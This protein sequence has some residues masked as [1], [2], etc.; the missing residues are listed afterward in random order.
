M[1]NPRDDFKL[2]TRAIT[3]RPVSAQSRLVAASTWCDVDVYEFI[4]TA[5]KD[6]L[7]E[8]EAAM[9]EEKNAS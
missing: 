2:T 7:E 3:F 9:G 6:R 1:G 8:V 4:E 5:I